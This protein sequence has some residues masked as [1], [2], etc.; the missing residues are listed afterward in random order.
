M[1]PRRSADELF[2]QPITLELLHIIAAEETGMRPI[3]SRPL[4][5]SSN[6][7]GDHNAQPILPVKFKTNGGKTG[8]SI[9][10][11]HLGRNFYQMA[12]WAATHVNHQ[13]D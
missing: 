1:H 5:N 8:F 4:R 9:T 2:L 7:V 12:L 6:P 11:V 10:F 13:V 3:V